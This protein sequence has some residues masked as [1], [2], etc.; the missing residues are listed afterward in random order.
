MASAIA[1][2]PCAVATAI[3][4][5]RAARAAGAAAAARGAARARGPR[6][7]RVAA[8]RQAD[9]VGAAVRRQRFDHGGDVVGEAL[10]RVRVVA[11][12]R[13]TAV[14]AQIDRR[15]L[16]PLREFAVAHR[17]PHAM[18]ERV[19]VQQHGERARTRRMHGDPRGAAVRRRRR[20]DEAC[21]A[22]GFASRRRAT[23]STWNVCGNM[24]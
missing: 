1:A 5:S 12:G 7:R 19:A 3:A 11:G 13:G 23:A 6:Q 14:P 20:I 2:A 8:H 16:P 15:Q 21:A 18:V 17:V 10:H 4:A 22:H 24:S 9:D